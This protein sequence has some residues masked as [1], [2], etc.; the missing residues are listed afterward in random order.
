MRIDG[1]CSIFKSIS[2]GVRQRC[3]MSLDV[4]ND[5]SEMILRKFNNHERFRINGHTNTNLGYSNDT[6]LLAGSENELQ[7]IIDTVVEESGRGD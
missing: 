7:L 3:E 2:R 6:V 4:L 5:Y 1:E